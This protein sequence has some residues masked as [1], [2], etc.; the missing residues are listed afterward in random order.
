VTQFRLRVLTA[1]VH[2]LARHVIALQPLRSISSLPEL[3]KR[4][5]ARPLPHVVLKENNAM[6]IKEFPSFL[7]ISYAHNGSISFL[8]LNPSGAGMTHIPYSLT[9]LAQVRQ[10]V[11]WAVAIGGMLEKPSELVIQEQ[12][13]PVRS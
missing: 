11:P 8:S 9:P 10:L 6:E 7:L 13:Y 4:Q 3:S 5:R 1:F 12:L 2:E